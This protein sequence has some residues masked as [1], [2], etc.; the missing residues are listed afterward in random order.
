MLF[1]A[2]LSFAQALYGSIVGNVTNN[3]NAVVAGATARVT[4]KATT[5][6]RETVTSESGGYTFTTVQTGT[7]EISVSK[8]RFKTAANANVIVTLNNITRADMALEVWA[9]ADTVTVTSGKAFSIKRS[10]PM[11]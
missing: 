10:E 5:Q 1:L 4:N 9:V 3:S 8:Q 11:S 7:W 6:T 2:P